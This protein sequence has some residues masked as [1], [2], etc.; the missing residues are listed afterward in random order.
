MIQ[1]SRVWLFMSRLHTLPQVRMF[2][3]RAAYKTLPVGRR[4]A[5]TGATNVQ[6]FLCDAYNET[7]SHALRDCSMVA[8][9]LHEAGFS[10]VEEQLGFSSFGAWMEHLMNTLLVYHFITLLI[11]L[12]KLWHRRNVFCHEGHLLP[13]W[14]LI[15]SGNALQAAFASATVSSSSLAVALSSGLHIHRWIKPAAGTFKLN[16]DGACPRPPDLPA[17]GMILRNSDGVVMARRAFHVDVPRST[18]FV[19]ALAIAH[20]VH[21][22]ISVEFRGWRLKVITGMLFNS[23]TNLQ[24]IALFF[25]FIFV[26]LVNS[27]PLILTFQLGLFVGKLLQIMLRPFPRL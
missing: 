3:W 20:G 22:A 6:C 23:S 24:V 9:I 27:W 16:V 7:V 8:P 15:T 26:R 2:G 12:W 1:P 5:F 10:T 18:N 17:I 4:L 19:E 13:G 11:L 25:S 14:Q 21:L